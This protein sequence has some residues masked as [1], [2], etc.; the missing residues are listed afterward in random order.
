[1]AIED[2]PV[3]ALGTYDEP[4]WAEVP[5]VASTPV[6]PS[7]GV[8]AAGLGNVTLLAGLFNYLF[9]QPYRWLRALAH[10]TPRSDLGLV[11]SYVQEGG[12]YATGGGTLSVALPLTEVWVQ[13]VLVQV[14]DALSS[15]HVFTASRDS[16]LI[17]N[18]AG[19]RT[20]V[21]TALG[22]GVPVL[23]PGEVIV[24]KTVTDGTG[25]VTSTLS[26]TDVPTL[27]AIGIDAL[28]VIGNLDVTGNATVTGTL[29]V[30][31]QTSLGLLDVAND[32]VFQ[33]N[34]EIGGNLDMTSGSISNVTTLGTSGLATLNSASVSTTLGVTGV[35]TATGGISLPSGADA[36]GTSGSTFTGGTFDAIDPTGV[37]KVGELTFYSD[38]SPS[39][40]NGVMQW[41]GR[42]LTVGLESYARRVAMPVDNYVASPIDTASSTATGASVSV[43]LVTGDVVYV[44]ASADLTNSGA[45]GSVVVF[46]IAIGGVNQN[47]PGNLT[48]P[49]AGKYI[50]CSRTVM[51]TA[52]ATAI[53][54]F[55]QRYGATSGT[56]SCRNSFI[57]VRQGNA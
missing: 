3:T 16:Y 10:R 32:A 18:T 36:T 31:G 23:S 15:P 25:V 35:L 13:G 4:T 47:S 19:V 52:P 2:F 9:R 42:G 48:H 14:A 40:T 28:D 17:L 12:T 51:Y 11:S 39:T 41:F 34:V 24:S 53:Y 22:A 30:T 38:S 7:A 45:S 8:A 33:L 6:A 55:V 21:E 29:D 46:E 56:G 1:M 49:A 5:T 57:S 20:D 50:T 44:T 26:L 37:V 43:T 54:T 27:G